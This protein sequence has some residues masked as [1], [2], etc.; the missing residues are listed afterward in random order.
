M[1][2]EPQTVMASEG[3]NDIEMPRP[4]VAP[5]TV[6]LGAALMG[7]GGATNLAFLV[8]GAVIHVT[9]SVIFGLIYGVLLPTLPAIPNPLAWGGLLMPLLWTAVS[10]SLME[11]VNPVLQRGV[12]W[13][14]FIA[15]QFVFGIAT[16][17]VVMR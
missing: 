7:M 2:T 11:V 15:S 8:V 4:T 1:A 16:A 3:P 9:M 12:E 14:W 6:S 13:P 10:F 17:V 5:L